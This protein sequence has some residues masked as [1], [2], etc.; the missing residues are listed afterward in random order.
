M[1]VAPPIVILFSCLI[2]E[3]SDPNNWYKSL[4]WCPGNSLRISLF[5]RKIFLSQNPFL[6]TPL[7]RACFKDSENI[8]FVIF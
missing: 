5:F 7:E 6:S 1:R 3:F 2:E 8:F 4:V